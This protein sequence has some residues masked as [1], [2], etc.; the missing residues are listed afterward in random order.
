MFIPVAGLIAG[1]IIGIYCPF[2]FPQS[3]SPYV[4]IAILA[5][6]D[7]VLGG[8]RSNLEG[9]FHFGIFISGFFGNAILS[10]ILVWMGNK[11][12]I[13]LSIAAIVVYGSRLFENFA[14]IRRFLLNK[15]KK[16]D[17]IY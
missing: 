10:T 13:Q 1:I 5:C 16:K 2:T 8:V 9:K 14:H 7:S 11:L 17:S 12:N 4:A 6:I 3:Y 15:S